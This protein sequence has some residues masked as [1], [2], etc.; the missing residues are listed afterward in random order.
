MAGVTEYLKTRIDIPI[1]FSKVVPEPLCRSTTCLFVSR[2]WQWYGCCL[3]NRIRICSVPQVVI[4]PFHE[5][6]FGGI[7]HTQLLIYIINPALSHLIGKGS[8]VAAPLNRNGKPSVAKTGTDQVSH[9]TA[10]SVLL[11]CGRID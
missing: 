4:A 6:P 11:P 5:L 2:V 1:T 10:L 8:W 7:D 9:F 3:I